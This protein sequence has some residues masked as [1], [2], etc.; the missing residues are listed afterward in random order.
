LEFII[1]LLGNPPLVIV[2]LKI[3]LRCLKI[4][5]RFCIKLWSFI[6]LIKDF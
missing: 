2:S 1:N 3:K 4:D 5:A 6:F